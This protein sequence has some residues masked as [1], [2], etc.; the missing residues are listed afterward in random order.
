MAVASDTVDR[1]MGAD[2]AIR[3]WPSGAWVAGV[4]ACVRLCGSTSQMHGAG[5]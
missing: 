1:M 4:S 5:I 3:P 2:T